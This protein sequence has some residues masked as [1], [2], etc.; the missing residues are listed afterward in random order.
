MLFLHVIMGRIRWLLWLT[1]SSAVFTKIKGYEKSYW[2][3]FWLLN[4]FRLFIRVKQKRVK[5]FNNCMS[6]L[7]GSS[8]NFQLCLWISAN[9][10]GN[11]NTAKSLQKS[12][13]QFAIRQKRYPRQGPGSCL[14]Y[15]SLLITFIGKLNNKKCFKILSLDHWYRLIFIN[16]T[17]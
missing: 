10:I 6:P 12:R 5:D 8:I 15:T 4:L 9:N 1:F 7:R 2:S 3:V 16:F 17:L 13:K 14:C 11:I